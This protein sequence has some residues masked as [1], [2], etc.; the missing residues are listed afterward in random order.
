MGEKSELGM[1]IFSASLRHKVTGSVARLTAG[2]SLQSNSVS[3][4]TGGKG[5]VPHGRS[6]SNCG[7]GCLSLP[8]RYF[9]YTK[10]QF[11][12]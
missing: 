7:F 2:L 10:S 4:K 1:Y 11:H 5:T 6:S 9:H 12:C 3:V 8:K